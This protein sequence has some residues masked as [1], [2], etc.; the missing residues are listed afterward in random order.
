MKIKKCKNN[1]HKYE[2]KIMIQTKV[3]VVQTLFSVF[4]FTFRAR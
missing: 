2:I 4:F 1:Y 3:F